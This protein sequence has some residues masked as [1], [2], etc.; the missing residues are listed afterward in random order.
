MLSVTFAD[1]PISWC[2]PWFGFAPETFLQERVQRGG[3]AAALHQ[4]QRG[5]AVLEHGRLPPGAEG[6]CG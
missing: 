3:A 5:R 1:V 2:G 6:Q 4:V